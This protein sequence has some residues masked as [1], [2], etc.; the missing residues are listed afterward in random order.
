MERNL[1]IRD[2]GHFEITEGNK[3]YRLSY[4]L[5]KSRLTVED[6]EGNKVSIDKRNGRIVI[7]RHNTNVDWHRE[8]KEER[9]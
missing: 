2:K 4:E 7:D 6:E 9:H 3:R 1:T 5:F 8:N